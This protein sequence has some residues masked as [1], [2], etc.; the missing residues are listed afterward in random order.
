MEAIE[1]RI[2]DY[3]SSSRG[4]VY[5]FDK[6]ALPGKDLRVFIYIRVSTKLQEHRF[7]LKAQIQELVQY[8]HSMGWVIVGIYRDVDSGGKLDK[9]GLTQLLDDVD[10]DKGDVVLCID[11]DRLSR[12][13]TVSWEYLKSQLR[14]NSVKIAEPGKITDL[15]DEDD[16]FFSDLKNL[17]AKREKKK[18]VK[19]MMRGKRQR[20]REGKGWGKPPFEYL[21]DKNTGKHSINE[22]YSWVIPTIDDLYLKQGLSDEKIA[23]VLNGI[24]K[25]PSGKPWNSQHISKRLTSKAYHGVMEKSFSNGETI[26]TPGVYPPLRTEE[27]WHRI[28]L[29]RKEKYQRRAPIY[30]ALTRNIA[31]TCGC[32]GRKLS[33]KQSGSNEYGIHFYY[34]HGRQHKPDYSPDCGMS[35]NSIRIDFNLLQA[36]KDILNNEETARRYIQFEYSPQDI[37]QLNAEIAAVNRQ[38]NEV[39]QMYDNLLDLVLKGGSGFSAG[40]LESKQAEL[41]SQRQLHTT[42]KRQLESKKEAIMAKMFNYEAVSQYF[43]ALLY[44]DSETTP[45]EQMELIG[46]LFPSGVLYEDKLVLQAYLNGETPFPVTVPVAP[47]P[48][49]YMNNGGPRKKRSTKTSLGLAKIS[50]ETKKQLF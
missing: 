32:C 12:L 11:Q 46:R 40:L 7:S 28:Q 35:I 49:G 31:V 5:Y 43:E 8:A 33:L 29:K 34:K 36:V 24:K 22:A 37:D 21:Y 47:N 39:Q 41:E 15:A 4:A 42:R 38:L 10:D 16:E 14:E 26:V 13:D 19:R 48:F 44:L 45:Q 23:E 3:F 1:Q 25:P 20:T 2:A 18:I 27:T 50:E 9:A 6:T 30:P 17:F